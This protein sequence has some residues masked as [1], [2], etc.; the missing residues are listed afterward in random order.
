MSSQ[1]GDSPKA[2]AHTDEVQ[3]EDGGIE[4]VTISIKDIGDASNNSQDI[5][6]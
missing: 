2:G 6:F 3:D 4:S 1:G 5:S